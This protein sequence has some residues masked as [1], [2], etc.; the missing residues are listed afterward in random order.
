MKPMR[1]AISGLVLASLAGC[2]VSGPVYNRPVP[3]PQQVGVAGNWLGTDGVALST[4]NGGQFDS[5]ALDT[6]AKLATGNY[7]QRDAQNVSIS[8]TSLIRN[9]TTQVNCLLVN[10]QQMNCTT[11]TGAQ[12]TLLRTNR[13]PPTPVAAIEPAPLPAGIGAVSPNN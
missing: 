9:T 7:S 4:F 8:L 5:F 13:T 2:T 3:Q 11:Q 1:V 10:A 6:G 12:F